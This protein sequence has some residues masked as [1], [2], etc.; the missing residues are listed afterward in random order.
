MRNLLV[1]VGLLFH[2]ISYA[3]SRYFLCG[4]DEDG[5]FEDQVQHCACVPYDEVNY[6]KAYCLDFIDNSKRCEPL[7]KIPDCSPYYIYKDQ[8]ECLAA[9]FQSE[10]IP[11][12]RTTTLAY[13]QQNHAWICEGNGDPR[14]C[15]KSVS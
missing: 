9:L 14:T 15:I 3:D 11:P 1:L 10:P 5:C 2:S 12:C 13:C 8:G 6:N 4:P 7:S